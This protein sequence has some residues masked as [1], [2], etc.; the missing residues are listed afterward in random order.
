[1]ILIISWPQ[2]WKTGF[3]KFFNIEKFGPVILISK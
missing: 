2:L 1:V 3:D